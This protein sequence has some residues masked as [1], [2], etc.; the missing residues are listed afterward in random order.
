MANWLLEFIKIKLNPKKDL[1][2]QIN[3]IKISKNNL[4]NTI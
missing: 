4:A 1:P 2:N 3:Q